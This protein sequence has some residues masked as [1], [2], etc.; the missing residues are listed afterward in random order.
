LFNLQKKALVMSVGQ[1][2]AIAVSGLRATALKANTAANTIVNQNSGGHQAVRAETVSQSTSKIA[3][4]VVGRLIANKE[5]DVVMEFT[6]LI[7]AKAAYSANAEV[8][9]TVEEMEREFVNII[10]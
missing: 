8:I 4:G 10:A 7:E 1:T 6:H 2:L 3:G 9:R 5:V